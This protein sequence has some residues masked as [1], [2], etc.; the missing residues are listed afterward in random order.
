M[1]VF[2]I[3]FAAVCLYG[4]K[5]TVR[6]L[7][8]GTVKKSFLPQLFDCEH[9]WNDYLSK[10][11]TASVKGIFVIVVLL[12][13]YCNR[14]VFEAGGDRLVHRIL[15]VYIGQL[16]VTMFLF[17]SGYG[18]MESY[19]RKGREY[20]V[21]MP[22]QK[23]L[24]LLF[25]FDIVVILF[26]IVNA[27]LGKTYSF[28]YLLRALIGWRSMDNGNWF[29]FAILV[30]Y[31]VS[32]IAFIIAKDRYKLSAAIIT[33]LS[34]AYFFI[35][36]ELKNTYWYN[37]V[38]C[39]AFGVWYSVLHEKIEG[40]IQRS[41]LI[42]ITAVCASGAA[43]AVLHYLKSEVSEDFFYPEAIMFTVLIVLAT[44][45]F[46]IDNAFLRAVGAYVFESYMFQ[47]IPEL[48]MEQKGL[49]NGEHLYLKFIIVAAVTA[50]LSVLFKMLTKQTAKI[51]KKALIKI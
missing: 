1:L 17:Y 27:C 34:L 44:M 50:V 15:G 26:Y 10:D 32:F 24:K 29:I 25:D 36:R 19:K 30:M 13:H 41:N 3:I 51:F 28:T 20:A 2:C 5:I 45:K 14:C 42:W 8:A 43:V 16:M 33:V 39:Y 6:P 35:M 12:S 31:A 40:F 4:M 11:K 18:I 49:F 46:S 48:I 47:N 22:V 7:H 37:T 21:N 23:I 38:L 9:S